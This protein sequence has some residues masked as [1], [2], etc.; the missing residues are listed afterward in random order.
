MYI[1]I[2]T[3][4]LNPSCAGFI[5]CNTPKKEADELKQKFDQAPMGKSIFD[6]TSH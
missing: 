4:T 3:L 2:F 1:T 6:S 5:W